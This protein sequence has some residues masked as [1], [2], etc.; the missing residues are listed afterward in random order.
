MDLS[1]C[2]KLEVARGFYK[3]MNLIILDEPSSAPDPIT[4]YYVGRP[5]LHA[6]EGKNYRGR[7]L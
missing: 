3:D 6:G 1:E 7:N 5:N 2:Q 4:E